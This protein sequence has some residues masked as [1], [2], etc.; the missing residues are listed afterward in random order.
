MAPLC[1]LDKG[2]HSWSSHSPGPRQHPAWVPASLISSAGHT[3]VRHHQPM[4]PPLESLRL[5]Q[6]C[7]ADMLGAAALGREA[8]YV[9]GHRGVT[10]PAL[11]LPACKLGWWEEQVHGLRADTGV[12]CWRQRLDAL[13]DLQADWKD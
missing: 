12:P 9:L 11:S 13:E 1:R 6:A 3:S 4:G 8:H 10:M 2:P 5:R 7:T